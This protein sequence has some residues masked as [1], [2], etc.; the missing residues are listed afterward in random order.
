[1]L[2]WLMHQSFQV[3]IGSNTI[4]GTQLMFLTNGFSFVR[5]T[6]FELPHKNVEAMAELP[7][8][9]LCFT[10]D[11]FLPVQNELFSSVLFSHSVMSD[12][13][14]PHGLWHARPPCLSPAPG[15]YSNSFPLSWWCYSTIS[16]SVVP[17]SFCLQSFPASGSFPMSQFFPSGGQSIRVSALVSV[18]PKNI[19]D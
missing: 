8:C 10:E 14:W 12:S 13:L 17:F 11:I 16:S 18:L 1:M 4:F 15:V 2:S 9:G 3:L 6:Y 7:G 19:Q 5:V